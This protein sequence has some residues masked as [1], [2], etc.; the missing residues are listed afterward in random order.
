MV[1]QADNARMAAEAMAD[2]LINFF[3]FHPVHTPRLW[4]IRQDIVKIAERVIS[5]ESPATPADNPPP[6]G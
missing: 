4:A 5:G 1:S 6:K 3:P 2:A